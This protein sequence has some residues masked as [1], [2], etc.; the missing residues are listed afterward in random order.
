MT[1]VEID[2]PPRLRGGCEAAIDEVFQR[3]D[4]NAVAIDVLFR[5]ADANAIEI[6]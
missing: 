3:A 4:A 2:R 6:G 5:P 1:A